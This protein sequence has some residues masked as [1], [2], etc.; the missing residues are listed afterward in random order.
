MYNGAMQRRWTILLVL[1]L[2][3]A[4]CTRQ[5]ESEGGVWQPP[6]VQGY[7]PVGTATPTAGVFVPPTRQPAAP[8]LTPTPN[9]PQPIPTLRAQAQ[10]YVV[11]RGDTLG[12]LALRFDVSV[13]AL[14]QANHLANPNVLEVGQ[15]LVIPAP[16]PAATAP[17]FKIIPDSELVASPSNA[18]FDVEQ[19]VAAQGGYLSTY[20]EEVDGRV[21]T[22]AQMVAQ[23]AQDYSVNP[24]V[25]LALLEY[26]SGWVTHKKVSSESKTYP[27]RWLDFQRKGLWRQLHWAANE[28]NRGFYLWQAHGVAAFPLADGVLVRANPQVNAGTA[29]IQHV[30]ALLDG[31]SDW[32]RAVGPQGLYAT[33][34]ALFGYPF[35]YA[36][37]PL[38]PPDLQ[39][40]PMQLPF[41]P[42]V[43]W[44]FTGGPHGGWDDGSAWAAL[45]FAPGDV[46]LGA[47]CARSND[48][49][50]AVADGLVV[51]SADGAVVQDLDGDGY[52][53][54][55]WN[56]L[57]MH[58][59]SR[60]RVKVGTYL[61]AGERIGH[62]SCE[63][64]FS[65][66]THLHL[67]RKYN[68]VW[69]AADGPIPFVLDG[70]VSEGTGKAYD[71]YLRRGNQVKE[72]CECQKPKNTL[73]R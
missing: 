5:W 60:D 2:M 17:L 36:F 58:I 30:F 23:V 53:Q 55:G 70:W 9:A 19:F 37:E 34:Q 63:G 33:Y 22:G 61:H 8:L 42:G 29:A 45:D 4:A 10:K 62:P 16:E 68:G 21:M 47:G 52:E 14:V 13:D 71:G 69:I 67:A 11:Q 66:A 73:V 18:L 59:A 35:D 31:L 3:L 64:G 1:G 54:S 44:Y 12:S 25:L 50:V 7:G 46:P 43:K 72:A 51:R 6:P 41:E 65:T 27:F 48:W 40:P 26:Q 57:Y 39:Q 38:V 24:R 28:L 15:V 32:Q 49:V 56:V 20:T